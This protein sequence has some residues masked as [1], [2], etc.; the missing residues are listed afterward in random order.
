MRS[1]TI[2]TNYEQDLRHQFLWYVRSRN[3]IRELSRGD[4]C[5]GRSSAIS[6]ITV[7]VPCRVPA[8]LQ[9]AMILEDRR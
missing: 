7:R 4:L 3:Q 5:D 9:I 1:S 8:G 6:M 2:I